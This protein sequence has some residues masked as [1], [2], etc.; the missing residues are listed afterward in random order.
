MCAQRNKATVVSLAEARKDVRHTKKQ[1]L[2]VPEV[3]GGF[4]DS[5]LKGHEDGQALVRENQQLRAMH[6]E[7]MVS[8]Q[9]YSLYLGSLLAYISILVVWAL[10]LN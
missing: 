2:N 4:L 9:E 5:W 7:L 3:K 1:E 8:K 10:Q 6:E